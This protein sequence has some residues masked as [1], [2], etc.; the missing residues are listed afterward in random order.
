M[1]LFILIFELFRKFGIDLVN[2]EMIIIE[3]YF[4]G[5]K[6]RVIEFLYNRVK[7]FLK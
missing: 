4:G 6:D 7:E 1:D 2:Y 3:R 5:N